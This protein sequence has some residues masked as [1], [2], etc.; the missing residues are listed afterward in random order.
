MMI[1]P[2]N[3]LSTQSSCSIRLDTLVGKINNVVPNGKNAS[4]ISDFQKYMQEKGSS[5]NHQVNNLK[6]IIDFAKFLFNIYASDALEFEAT[7]NRRVVDFLPALFP[8]SNP[9]EKNRM[10]Q[11]LKVQALTKFCHI[12]KI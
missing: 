11:M 10:L 12:A 2:L 6:V 1:H 5:E 9:P 3:H 8:N 7:V 4:I